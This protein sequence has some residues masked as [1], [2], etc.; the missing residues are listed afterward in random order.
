LAAFGVVPFVHVLVWMLGL[1]LIGHPHDVVSVLEEM[2]RRSQIHLGFEHGVNPLESHWPSWLIMHHPITIKS[3]HI[4]AK[5]ALASSVGNPILFAAGD[6]C[7]VALP[8]AA[9]LARRRADVR[10]RFREIFDAHATRAMLLLGIAWVSMMLLW[11]TG[12]ITTYWYHYLTPWGILLCLL[13]GVVA[14]L[15]RHF[16]KEVFGFVVAVLVVAAFFAPVWAEI[17]ISRSAAN[18]RLIFPLWR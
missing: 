2:Y 3:A 4:G 18:Q 15:D 16:P 17:P 9:L 1:K 7:L 14:R 13:G 12:R 6:A 10:R 11:F 5:V 8:V